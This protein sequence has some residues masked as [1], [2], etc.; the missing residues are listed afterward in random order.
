[1]EGCV[2][3]VPDT[4]LV[5]KLRPTG[6]LDLI[7]SVS[8]LPVMLYDMVRHCHIYPPRVIDLSD[9]WSELRL[10]GSSCPCSPIEEEWKRRARDWQDS[11]PFRN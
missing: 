9:R 5:P 1:M 4:G 2:G 6:F 10:Q 7:E 3:L 8:T 11:G